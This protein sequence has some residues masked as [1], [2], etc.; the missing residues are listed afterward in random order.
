MTRPNI[1]NKERPCERRWWD[2]EY[3]MVALLSAGRFHAYTSTSARWAHTAGGA[4]NATTLPHERTTT[5]RSCLSRREERELAG[6]LRGSSGLIGARGT[7]AGTLTSVEREG[8]ARDP[9]GGARKPTAMRTNAGTLVARAS[10]TWL[11]AQVQVNVRTY[12]R[13]QSDDAAVHV[14]TS[15]C[16]V[17][18]AYMYT[19]CVVRGT[20]VFVYGFLWRKHFTHTTHAP[21]CTEMRARV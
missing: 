11:P 12:T 10:C 3:S 19:E 1:A 17:I 4:T 7:R 6:E 13:I 2:I 15:E 5:G 16:E 18:S 14:R 8:N 20:L 21:V 9:L